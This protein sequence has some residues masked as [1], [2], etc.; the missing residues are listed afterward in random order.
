MTTDPIERIVNILSPIYGFVPLNFH[1]KIKF[2]KLLYGCGILTSIAMS[3]ETFYFFN[4]DFRTHSVPFKP[5]QEKTAIFVVNIFGEI[6]NVIV[7]GIFFAL[8]A[9]LAKIAKNFT[10]ID[11]IILKMDYCKDFSKSHR[12]IRVFFG[13]QLLI[14]VTRSLY[15]LHL[16]VEVKNLRE[17]NYAIK[18]FYR[19]PTVFVYYAQVIFLCHKIFLR[20][21]AINYQWEVLLKSTNCNTH[22]FD[23]EPVVRI[24]KIRKILL[25]V[26]TLVNEFFGFV[27]S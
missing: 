1:K 16:L 10:Q 20:F 26:V 8:R 12:F 11:D 21:R 7:I 9:K 18:L 5:G 27:V 19:H 4:T 17:F 15:G 13:L 23:I 2:L 25:E 24:G 22:L 6:W 3:F 14:I